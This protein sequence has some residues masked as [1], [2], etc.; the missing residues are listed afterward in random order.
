MLLRGFSTDVLKK[1]D[2]GDD[3]EGV[4]YKRQGKVSMVTPRTGRSSTP[5][6]REIERER[7][8]EREREK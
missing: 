6:V 4:R 2:S 8:R 1:A 3:K 5:E 7:E